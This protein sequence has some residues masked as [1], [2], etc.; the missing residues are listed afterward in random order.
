MTAT[1]TARIAV[2]L[3]LTTLAAGCG[4]RPDAVDTTAA[5]G[6]G[7]VRSMIASPQVEQLVYDSS[8]QH[9]S[10]REMTQILGFND[11]QKLQ[12]NGGAVDY[13]PVARLYALRRDRTQQEFER[14]EGAMVAVLEVDP[15]AQMPPAYRHLDIENNPGTTAHVYCVFLYRVNNSQN[16]WKGAVSRATGSDCATPAQKIDADSVS[17]PGFEQASDFPPY[18][19]RFME[20]TN[21][22]PSLGVRCY[23]AICEIGN[24]TNTSAPSNPS[25][26]KVAKIRTWND[27]Q[28]IAE[29]RQ[30]GGIQ[31]GPSASITPV[32]GLAAM[33]SEFQTPTGAKAA[34]IFVDATP[35][36]SK[37][38]AW[39]LAANTET[40]VWLKNDVAAG[41]WS[42]QFRTGS[43][44]TAWTSVTRQP[45]TAGLVPGTARWVWDPNDEGIWIACDQGCCEMGF[46]LHGAPPRTD[47]VRQDSVGSGKGQKPPAP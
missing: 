41:Q 11:Q 43:S 39:G 47:S 3:T 24:A 2:A 31:R 44:S 21:G 38:A 25:G 9:A 37:Y 40:E 34:T 32:E 18:A 42:M 14:P 36:G 16:P 15:E 30:G 23:N 33:S 8:L 10:A 20:S 26:G 29:P 13:G 28:R 12:A 46:T 19:V 5:P 17:E 4:N 35:A 7:A 27:K 22:M 1:L 6:A 45:H